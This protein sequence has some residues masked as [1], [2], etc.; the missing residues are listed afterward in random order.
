[1]SSSH[2]ILLRYHEV[3]LK[4]GNRRWFEDRL[5][6]NACKL[7]KR[8]LGPDTPIEIK[9]YYG[10]ITLETLWNKQTQ[11]ALERVFGLSSFSP[12][13]RVTTDK[14]AITHA[15]LA[16]V[17]KFIQEH[18][19]VPSSFR[20]KTRRSDKAFPETSMELDR[21]F[22]SVLHDAYPQMKVDLVRPELQV[23]IEIHFEDSFLWTEKF[24][25]PGG[26]PVGTN[27]HLL[28]LMSG[29]LDSPVAAIQA[30]R[31]GAIAHFIHFYGTPFVGQEALEKVENLVAIVNRY[32]PDPQPLFVVPFGRIQEKIALVTQ[33]KVRTVLY[34]RMMIR[35]ANA[36]A[37]KLKIQALVTGE[38]LGQ[39]ASQTLEN[40]SIINAASQ[41]PILRPLITYDK[42]EI[43]EY[44]QK[45]GTYETSI[46]PALDCCTLFA[47][48][49]PILKA[50]A[51]LIEEQESRFSIPELVAQ[52]LEET[53]SHKVFDRT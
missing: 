10:R 27:S 32:Q 18:K 48:R 38:S 40:L 21:F 30:L 36:L 16:E 35:I 25:G 22:G 14:T 7:I 28:C 37:E 11:G 24:S 43:I 8:A 12:M 26:L 3:A 46:Q 29:G 1:M 49:H 5:T 31:R 13:R 44:A 6:L 23:G 19:K 17:E 52:A 42:D 45:W 2:S 47:D 34:R 20:V 53:S 50:S 9:K 15:A 51:S 33:P 39:V 4:G 41:I